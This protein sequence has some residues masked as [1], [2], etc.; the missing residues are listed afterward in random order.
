MRM[1]ETIVIGIPL[2]L[3]CVHILVNALGLFIG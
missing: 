3:F 1:L 2:G